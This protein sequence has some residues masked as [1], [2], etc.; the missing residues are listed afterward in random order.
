M[1]CFK[2]E[3]CCHQAFHLQPLTLILPDQGLNICMP[4]TFKYKLKFRATTAKYL[5]DKK[6]A[7][8]G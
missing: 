4:A 6:G 8:C 7:R 1:S 3:N 2:G 5:S